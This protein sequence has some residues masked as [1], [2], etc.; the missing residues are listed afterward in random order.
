MQ[1]AV[2]EL[3]V[4]RLIDHAPA[5][6][7]VVLVHGL[8]GFDRVRVAGLTVVDYFPGIAEA[9]EAAGNRVLVPCSSRPPASPTGPRSSRTFLRESRPHEP[10]HLIA[11]SM[12]GLDARYMISRAGHGRARAVADDARHAAPRLPPS[13]TG[14]CAGSS[15][16]RPAASTSSACRARPSTT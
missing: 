4:S 6:S 7:A 8:F 5:A 1:R 9:L 2:K 14:A 10:V 12:G 13:P 15:A 11:H 16:G 3:I